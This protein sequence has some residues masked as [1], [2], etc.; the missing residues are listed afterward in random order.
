[1]ISFTMSTNETE[2]QREISL[3]EIQNKIISSEDH[4]KWS[5]QLLQKYLRKLGQSTSGTKQHLV[6]RITN[7]K[8][9]PLVLEK[10]LQEKNRSY[11]FKSRLLKSEIPPVD[12]TWMCDSKHYPKVNN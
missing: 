8:E 3:Q 6:K 11:K 10:I 2:G 9:N 4:S 1:M 5:L 7:L 12:A